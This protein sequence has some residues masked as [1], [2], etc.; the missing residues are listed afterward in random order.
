VASDSPV[1][2]SERVGELLDAL[3]MGG[4]AGDQL[5]AMLQSDVR[6]HRVGDT[7]GGGER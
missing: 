3:E 1:G 7:D 5:Q 4:V 6:D 2:E